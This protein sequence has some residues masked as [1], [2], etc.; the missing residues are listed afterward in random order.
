[1]QTVMTAI[2]PMSLLL[3][4]LCGALVFGIG[5]YILTIRQCNREGRR[6]VASVQQRFHELNQHYATAQERIAVLQ[7]DIRDYTRQL[8]DAHGS[9]VQLQTLLDKEREL[10][11]E[12]LVL[13]HD[14]KEQMRVEFQTLSQ[15]IAQTQRQKFVI[16]SSEQ[17]HGVIAPFKEQIEQFQKQIHRTYKDEAKERSML[18]RELYH[19]KELNQT[20]SNEAHG[21]TKALKGDSKQQGIWGEMVLEKVLEA[22]GLRCGHEYE[23][24][25]LLRSKADAKQYRPDVIVHLPNAREVVVDAKTSLRAYEC[26]V[27]AEEADKRAYLLQHVE[28]LYLHVKQLSQK[29]YT[30]LEGVHTV[31][32]VLMFIPMESALIAAMEYDGTLYERAYKKN[33]LLVSPSTLMIALRAI[34]SSWQYERSQKNALEIAQRAG[35]L[36]D[37]FVGFVQDM[38]KI[39]EHLA[40]VERSYANAYNKLHDGK[41]SL[42]SQLHKLKKMGASTSKTLPDNILKNIGEQ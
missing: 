2:E 20:L 1:M 23:R 17:L 35:I 25:V 3:G 7:N 27:N 36:Y 14:A 34:E 39:S 11:E 38:E 12:K 40:L 5:V 30:K 8:H 24:E 16:E 37:K 13:L 10:S 29:D 42:T 41:G 33:I 4:L 15:Q 21:L 22:S 32:F 18:Q 9:I 19:L 26:Y 31:D 28:A 6:I